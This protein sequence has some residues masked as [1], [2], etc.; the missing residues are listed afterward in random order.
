MSAK[1]VVLIPYYENRLGLI[2]AINSIQESFP[3]DLMIVD[4][5]SIKE[6][7]QVD[8]A[9]KIYGDRGT[10]IYDV[11]PKNRGIENALNMGLQN[12]LER[13]YKYIGR[14]DCGDR[15][16]KG[17]LE[18]Q[19]TYLEANKE[20]KLLGTWANIIDDKENFIYIEKHPVYY[21]EIK[22][23]IYLNTT[24]I[25]PSVVFESAILSQIGLY[26]V[27]YPAAEDY[28]FFMS[29]VKKYKSENYPEV[30][31]DYVV[32]PNSISSLKRKRQVKSRIKVILENYY[33]GWYP[34]YGLIR[35]ILLLLISR[36]ASNRIK[37]IIRK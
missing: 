23:K 16:H 19:I 17:K 1:I 20:V 33:L 36:T 7:L 6:P 30:L 31:M 22:K 27:S 11:L 29:I 8:E 2:D 10:I 18:K 32:D 25:H 26:P 37:S 34:S 15:F 9:Y 12:I 28:A 14:L 24:F 21:N 35:N 13:D 3:V 5:G 4:D